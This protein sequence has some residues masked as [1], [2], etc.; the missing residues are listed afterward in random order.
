MHRP[1][2]GRRRTSVAVAVVV[3]GW[4]ASGCLAPSLPESTVEDADASFAPFDP[5]PYGLGAHDQLRVTVLNHPELSTQG[6]GQLV[7]A[8]GWLSLPLIG[9]ISVDRRQPEEVRAEIEERLA[10]WIRAP[11][12]T[13]AVV[14]YGARQ[15]FVLGH[16]ASPGVYELDRPLTALQALTMCG[17]FQSGADRD[18]VVIV[19]RVN[20]EDLSVCVFDAASPGPDGMIRIEPDDL[21]F[22]RQTGSGTFAEQARPVLATW[23]TVFNAA[24]SVVNTLHTLDYL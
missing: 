16:V 11:S 19:R 14:A 22:V 21:L 20:R 7:D 2:D 3:A 17:G 6:A 24:S 8:E 18:N 4:A 9:A 23:S 13:V 10:R 15:L 1:S 5:T 12:V